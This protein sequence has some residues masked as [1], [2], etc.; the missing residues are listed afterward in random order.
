MN[1]KALLTQALTKLK[2]KQK[3]NSHIDRHSH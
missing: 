2:K 3:N 1:A